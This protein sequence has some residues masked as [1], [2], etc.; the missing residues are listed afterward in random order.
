[1]CATVFGVVSLTPSRATSNGGGDADALSR[2]EH[3]VV[4]FQENRSFDNIYGLLPGANGLAQA[5]MQSKVQVDL[6]GRPY[7][8]LPQTDPQLTSPP[9]PA[10]ACSKAA[11]DPVDSHF[12]N[13][14]FKIDDYVAAAEK[15]RDLVHRFYQEQ[16]QIDGGKMDR[17]VAVSDAKGLAMGVYE[18]SSLPTAEVLSSYTV[19]D[20]FFHAAFGGSFLNHAWLIC[21]CTPVFNDA[22]G[23]GGPDDLHTVLGPDGLPIA[24]RDRALTTLA[25]GDYAVNT[26]YSTYPPY[27]ANTPSAR[28]LP[29]QTATTIGDRLSDAGVSW[30]WYSGGWDDAVAGTPNSLFQYHH[31]AFNYF[32]NYA[33]G[34]PGRTHLK[35]ETEFINAARA[36]TLPAVSFV[37]PLGPDN[38]HPGY[39]DLVSGQRHVMDLIDAV[40]SGPNWHNTAIIVTYDENGGYWDHVAP[41]TDTAHSDR[42]GPGSRV[43]TLVVSPLAKRQFVD[44]TLYDTTS[45]LAT[46]EHRWNLEALGRRDAAAN[47][48][49]NGFRS[50]LEIPASDRASAHL[51]NSPDRRA[52]L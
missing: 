41:P 12:P 1:M 52:L 18:T 48:L 39:A 22:V 46:I 29:P 21:A 33:P 31:Q 34:T 19:A 7:K 5:S 28:R 49:R 4:I 8:C 30:A 24:G 50:D 17:F 27:P 35:D 26:I 32:A 11:G 14:P 16:V 36:G 15:T 43:P 9:L 23:D 40:R 44:H 3:F 25:D 6:T 45:I 13:E 2:I 38:E 42:W 47:D 51:R 10:D 20:N 37:K